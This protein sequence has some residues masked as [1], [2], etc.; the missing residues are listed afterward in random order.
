MAL[1][2][3]KILTFT[4]VQPGATVHGWWNNA[5]S[6]VYRLNA[7]PNVAA[8]VNASAEITAINGKVHGNPSE[9]ELHFDVKNTGAT[10]IDRCVGVG[11]ELVV[12]GHARLGAR[13]VRRPCVRM[14]HCYRT[15]D[16]GSGGVWHSQAWEL[17][18][19]GDR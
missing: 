9:R 8:G 15:R 5:N 4:N 10:A 12:A 16:Q 6:E 17:R 14:R 7:W 11:V 18:P 1:Q 2:G 19:S 13:G 3:V